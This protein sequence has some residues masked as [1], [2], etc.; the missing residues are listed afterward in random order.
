MLYD[1]KGVLEA[2]LELVINAQPRIHDSAKARASLAEALVKIA[3]EMEGDK[4]SYL[5]V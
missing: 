3:R 1:K 2:A 4:P 5:E